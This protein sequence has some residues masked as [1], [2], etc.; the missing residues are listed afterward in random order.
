MLINGIKGLKFPDVY[1]A[2]FFFKEN[3][4]K[5]KGKVLEL[6]CG[7]GNNLMLFYQYGWDVG[8]VD[9]DRTCIRNAKYNFKRCQDEYR[10]NNTYNFFNKDMV[11]FI[12]TQDSG[13]YDVLL[14]PSSM[15]Y[16]NYPRIIDLLTLVKERC[17]VTHNSLMFIITRTPND[18]RYNKGIRY[19]KKTFK[20][21]IKETDEYG[22]LMT[23]LTKPELLLILRKNFKFT[24]KRI[25]HSRFDNLQNGKLISNDDIIF[26]G[27][28][29]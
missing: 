9:N 10:L 3:L 19:C 29:A 8:G 20:L 26:W 7:N 24:F 25:F 22:C 2:R 23:F 14:V 28:L 6:G 16:L 27:R 21:G 13:P 5:R 15:Y 17:I 18:Y 12:K 11:D 1:I 4:D